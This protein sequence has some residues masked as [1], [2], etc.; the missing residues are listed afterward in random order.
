MGVRVEAG[1]LFERLR[2]RWGRCYDKTLVGA[3]TRSFIEQFSMRLAAV[4][5]REPYV[6]FGRLQTEYP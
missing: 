3:E 6:S 5:H 2:Q 1:Q 4:D